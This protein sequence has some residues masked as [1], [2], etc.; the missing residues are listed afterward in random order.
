MK[1]VFLGLILFLSF[2]STAQIDSI[3]RETLTEQESDYLNRH[4]NRQ[5]YNFDF[6]A[7]KVAFFSSPGGTTITSKSGFFIY[8]NDSIYSNNKFF[9][10]VIFNESQKSKHGYDVAMIYLSKNNRPKVSNKL[11]RMVRKHGNN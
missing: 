5:F 11:K 10:I 7:K 1:N 6:K 8:E 4:L 2:K 3:L 9:D